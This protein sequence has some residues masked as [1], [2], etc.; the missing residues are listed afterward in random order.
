MRDFVAQTGAHVAGGLD[1]GMVEGHG[2]ALSD[3]VFEGCCYEFFA[4]LC[5]HTTEL[6]FKG[7][8]ARL[9]PK[10]RTQ[11]A[12]GGRWDASAL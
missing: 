4:P 5:D 1:P 2:P 6:S 10:G 9:H 7:R 8:G 12:V 3:H 11:D